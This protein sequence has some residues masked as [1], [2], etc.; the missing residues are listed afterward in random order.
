[1]LDDLRTRLVQADQT[2]RFDAEQPFHEDAERI[3]LRG[4]AE[5]VRLAISY[6]DETR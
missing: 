5:G 6:L 3:R 1:M 2:L 4:K